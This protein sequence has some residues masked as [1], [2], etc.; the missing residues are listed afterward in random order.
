MKKLLYFICFSCL[1]LIA[2]AQKLF[3]I[4]LESENSTPFYIRVGDKVY[5][6]SAAGYL[7]LPNLEE[8]NYTFFL[9]FP[10]SGSKE[11]KF[12]LNIDNR[13]YGFLIKNSRGDVALQ[14]LQNQRTIKAVE[15]RAGNITYERRS[16]SFTAL[17]A[18][19]SG[20]SSLLYVPVY[21]KTVF[22]QMQLET[23]R[24]NK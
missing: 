12:N 9:G 19:A 22:E 20:D 23:G 7:L 16:D 8:Q 6:S 10:S 11:L 13:D 17:L 5:S 2:S 4:Y 24:R 15:D 21:A 18:R 14:D 3:F 1:F